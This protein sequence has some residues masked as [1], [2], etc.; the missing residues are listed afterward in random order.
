VLSEPEPIDD[1]SELDPQRYGLI[2]QS[3][4]E[5]QRRGLLLPNLENIDTVEKQVYWTR[6][7]KAGITDPNEP[8]QMYRFEVKRYT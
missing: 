5:P 8:V 6:H 2:V 1:E 3:I 4:A 7:H